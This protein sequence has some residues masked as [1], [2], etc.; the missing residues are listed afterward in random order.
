MRALPKSLPLAR[1]VALA[2]LLSG[3]AMADEGRDAEIAAL[4]AELAALQQ[5]LVALEA[6]NASAAPAGDEAK[7]EA[8]GPV[9]ASTGPGIKVEDKGEG[10]SFAFGGRIHY[11]VYAND[12]D[13]VP[14]TGGSEFRRARL[15]FDGQAAGWNYRVHAEF[16]GRNSDLRDFYLQRKLAGGTLTIGQFK[17]YRSLDELVSSNDIA[18][19]ERGWGSAAGFF[20][21]RQWQ[22]GVGYLRA[23]PAGSLGVAAFWLRE[24]NTARNEGWGSTVRGTWAPINDGQRLLHVGGWYSLEDGG[25][26]TPGTSIEIAYGGRRGPEALLFE[27]LDG[28]DFEQRSAG[29]EFAGVHGGFHWQS[30]WSRATV[31]GLGGDGRLDASYLQA[32]YI[33]GGT[34]GYSVGKGVFG[35]PT[36]IGDGLWELVARV[37]RLRLRDAADV[38]VRRVLLGANWYINDQLRLMLNWSRGEDRATGDEPS[39]LALRAQ[40]AF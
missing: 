16:S 13:L 29:V 37:D 30:E 38:E 27:S 20:A 17:P 3:P 4:R 9:L 5:R 2:L 7:T 21:D 14:A 36:D 26:D 19:M 40:Y 32:G 33:F 11:D 18:V 6:A 24:D 25:T 28:P 1:F 39:Q 31:A 23:L 12:E 22:Q 10:T 34:R 35:S 15:H 8:A